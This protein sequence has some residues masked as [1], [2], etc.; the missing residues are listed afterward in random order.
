MMS[1]RMHVTLV[2]LIDLL[3]LPPEMVADEHIDL[4]ETVGELFE[5]EGVICIGILPPR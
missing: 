2:I 5:H 1:A 4:F 3:L